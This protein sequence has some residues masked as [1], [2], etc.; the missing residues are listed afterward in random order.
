M[1][2]TGLGNGKNRPTV[3]WGV[4]AIVAKST[5]GNI[6]CVYFGVEQQQQQLA[7]HVAEI[8]EMISISLGASKAQQQQQQQREHQHQSMTMFQKSLYSCSPPYSWYLFFRVVF[9]AVAVVV[10][11][12]RHSASEQ[13]A[14]VC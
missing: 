2:S 1:F 12:I 4:V 7:M 11:V 9:V 3:L 10:V 14:D 8:T 6:F 5:N 13:N